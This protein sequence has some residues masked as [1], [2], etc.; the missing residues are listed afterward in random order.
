MTARL[1]RNPFLF[2]IS[3]TLLL[4][5]SGCYDQQKEA[6]TKKDPTDYG[7]AHHR[8]QEMKLYGTQTPPDKSQHHR[9]FYFDNSLAVALSHLN[10]V[11]HVFAVR[12]GDKAYIALMVDKSATGTMGPDWMEEGNNAGT[13][14]GNYSPYGNITV[15]PSHIATGYNSYDTA[16]RPQDLSHAFRQKIAETVRNLRPSVIEVHVSANRNFLNQL[17][18]YYQEQLLG[19][20]LKPYSQQF[21]NSV[22]QLFQGPSSAKAGH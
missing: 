8:S 14:V 22:D 12:S 9:D 1:L 2:L 7:L 3:L 18:F 6:A 11:N 20:P 16:Q 19:H 4:L 21:N 5:T 15:N 13:S 10:G 17:N